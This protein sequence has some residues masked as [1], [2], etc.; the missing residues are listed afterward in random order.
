MSEENSYNF[1]C[2]HC[3]KLLAKDNIEA[4]Q[5]EIKCIRCGTLNVLFRDT[6]EQIVVTDPTGV[7]LF[8]NGLTE[9]ITGYT[10]GEIIGKTPSLWGGLMPKEFYSNMWHQIKNE[11]KSISVELTNRRKNGEKYVA[12]LTISPVLNTEGEIKFFIGIESIK[13]NIT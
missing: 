4:G 10:L 3:D 7:I 12:N 2:T 5:F 8:A 13:N 6:K 1:R 9:V 11:K